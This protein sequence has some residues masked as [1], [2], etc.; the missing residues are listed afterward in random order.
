[1][2]NKYS[3]FCLNKSSKQDSPTPQK[4]RMMYNSIPKKLNAIKYRLDALNDMSVRFNLPNNI[5]YAELGERVNSVSRMQAVCEQILNDSACYS[6][7]LLGQYHED[8]EKFIRTFEGPYLLSSELRIFRVLLE[9]LTLSACFYGE[10]QLALLMLSTT[11]TLFPP[12]LPLAVAFGLLAITTLALVFMI[13]ECGGPAELAY[14]H[15]PGRKEYDQ[16]INLLRDLD[17]DLS[18]LQ[19]SI[20]TPSD[21]KAINDSYATCSIT[22]GHAT[23]R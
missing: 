15:K 7:Y 5:T 13:I 22:A 1:M 21:N 12:L 20:E 16:C 14:D 3:L 10:I 17:Q 8:L 19:N 4:I 6:P 18:D 9:L 2:N 23:T 11:V